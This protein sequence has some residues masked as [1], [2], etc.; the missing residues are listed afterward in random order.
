MRTHFLARISDGPITVA[1][2]MLYSF[3]TASEIA[4]E[5]V[6]RSN[7][8][9]EGWAVCSIQANGRHEIEEIWSMPHAP[10]A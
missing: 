4:R 2:K 1:M 7:W 9:R 8:G 3:D 5:Q 6:R 10:R